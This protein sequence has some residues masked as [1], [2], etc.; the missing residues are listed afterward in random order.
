MAV[1]WV[2][3]KWLVCVVVYMWLI[4]V[5]S[6][7]FELGALVYNGGHTEEYIFA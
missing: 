5:L 3:Q 1:Y 2:G 4:E 7:L 6:F